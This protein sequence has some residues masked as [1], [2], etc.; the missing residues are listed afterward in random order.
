[1][2]STFYRFFDHTSSMVL[3]KN[4]KKK[5]VIKLYNEGKTTREI[6]SEAMMSLKDIGIIIREINNEPEPLK[7]PRARAYQMF[8]D[9][10]NP[11]QVSIDLDIKYDEVI[12]KWKTMH[13][14]KFHTFH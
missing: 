9:G 3:S 6:A 11:T 5:L 12:E 7:S 8:S 1:M 10:Q 4:Q 13:T 14:K 2:K